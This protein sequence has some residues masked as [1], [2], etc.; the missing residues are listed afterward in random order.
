MGENF[1]EEKKIRVV[2]ADRDGFYLQRLKTSLERRNR[3]GVTVEV[4]GTSD[5]GMHT[6]EL[7]CM[8]KP[9]VLVMDVLLGERDGFWV[10]EE[11]TKREMKPLC[12]MVSAISTEQTVR[13]AM[14]LGA[15]YF[16]AKPM[17]GELLVQRISQFFDQEH[18]F[19]PKKEETETIYIQE[20]N[21]DRLEADISAMLSRMGMSASIKGYH[22]IRRA[23][24]MAVEDESVLV[25]ITKGLYPD[26]AKMY[27]TSSSKVERAIRH[28]ID[29]AWKKNGQQVYFEAAGFL[30]VQKPTNGQF[31]AALS[32]YFRLHHGKDRTR[33][34]S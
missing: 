19:S 16:M 23:V 9:D 22:Y 10:L 26:I 25:G 1:T 7:V 14:E 13:Q 34:A 31:I 18:S 17:Q 20:S 29:S 28:A 5:S 12:I 30:A 32:E 15:G 8:Q 27:R 11:L 6:V 24:L 33:T 4:V 2:L 21:A 3:Y